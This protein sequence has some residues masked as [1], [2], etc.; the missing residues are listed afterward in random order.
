MPAESPKSLVHGHFADSVSVAV[1]ILFVST[2]FLK[3]ILHIKSVEQESMRS[4]EYLLEGDTFFLLFYQLMF[5]LLVTTGELHI[6][7]CLGCD[8]STRS[9]ESAVKTI[10]EVCWREKGAVKR[11]RWANSGG[12]S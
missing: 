12:P 5:H 8:R 10:C 2:S 9:T 6:C 7:T 4:E 3:D 1:S 11:C